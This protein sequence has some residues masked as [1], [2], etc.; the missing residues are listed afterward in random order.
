MVA[1][2]LLVLGNVRHYYCTVKTV[3]AHDDS[4]LVLVGLQ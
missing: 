3:P 2:C 1:S 4:D